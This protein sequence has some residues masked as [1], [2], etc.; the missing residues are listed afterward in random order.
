MI[1]FVGLV[2]V[3]ETFN[4][5]RSMKVRLALLTLVS[6]LGEAG[7]TEQE[8][9]PKIPDDLKI[10]AGHVLLFKTQA[11][12]VQI[13]ESKEK[14]G[15]LVWKFKA[16]LAFLFRD[17]KRVG[18]HY[19]GPSWEGSDGSKAQW[20]NSEKIAGVKSASPKPAVDWLRIKVKSTGDHKGKYAAVSYI[21]RLETEGGVIPSLKA[22]RAGMEVGIP[23]KATYYFYG[24]GKRK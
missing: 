19:A 11:E 24:L 2:D 22:T 13:Y 17:G 4:K 8:N 21:L 6:F 12:G 15:M 10:P 7:G 23:Y 14:D 3:P 18:Y 16:P 9:G 20:D 5:E 1:Y